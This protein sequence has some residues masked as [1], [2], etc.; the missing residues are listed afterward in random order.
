M[1]DRVPSGSRRG[2]PVGLGELGRCSR[3]GIRFVTYP[4][5]A[6]GA[7]PLM[8]RGSMADYADVLPYATEVRSLG[9]GNTPLVHARRLGQRMGFDRLYLKVEGCNPTGSFKDR[10]AFVCVGGALAEGKRGVLVASSGNAGA[11]TAAYC[12]AN[13]LRCLL[14]VAPGVSPRK[15]AQA[16]AAGAR[17]LAVD[18]LFER[19]PE[20]LAAFLRVLAERL[21]LYLGFFWSPVNPHISEGFKT[22]SYET[23]T[24]LGGAPEWVITP[25]A[26]GDLIAGQWRGWLDLQRGGEVDGLPRMV[27]AQVG[28][29]PLVQAWLAKA[30]E[31]GVLA[32]AGRTVASALRT[33]FTGD[34]ALEAIYQSGGRA[35]LVE[36]EAILDAQRLVGE[37]EGLWIESA[38]AAALAALPQTGAAPA[39]VIVCVCTAA[40]FKDAGDQPMDVP[41]VPFDVERAGSLAR[42]LIGN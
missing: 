36:D 31:V 22:I 42:S 9:E 11:A 8:G 26:G 18:R 7:A 41:E 35:V 27:A 37:T 40:G 25:T 33:N 10:G 1:A 6:G 28:A 2:L 38:S 4:P 30:G 29:A 13:G 3:G 16:R 23:A 20:E 32:S 14:L 24:R 15:L 17:C 5:S 39:D 12:A 21:D 19:D 34:H